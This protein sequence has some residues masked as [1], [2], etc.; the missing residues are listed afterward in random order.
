MS[1]PGSGPSPYTDMAIKS[2]SEPAT[3][4]TA[5]DGWIIPKANLTKTSQQAEQSGKKKSAMAEGIPKQVKIKGSQKK[6]ESPAS[7]LQFSVKQENQPK[8]RGE[9]SIGYKSCSDP[10][11]GAVQPPAPNNAHIIGRQP[12][13]MQPCSP[14]TNN[15]Q[16]SKIKSRPLRSTTRPLKRLSDPSQA[17]RPGQARQAA[18]TRRGSTRRLVWRDA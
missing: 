9:P 4:H 12:T 15:H 13:R 3:S 5:D 11:P 18:Q 1:R 7:R 17:G 8:M 2:G 6:K 16:S 10:H 14:R